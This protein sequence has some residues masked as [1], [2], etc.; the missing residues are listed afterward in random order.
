[1]SSPVPVPIVDL[2]PEISLIGDHAL[3][4]QVVRFWEIAYAQSNWAD[5][6]TIDQIPY[7]TRIS[8]ASL[9]G[10]SRAVA[11]IAHDAAGSA[12]ALHDVCKIVESDPDPEHPGGAV[13]S[14][15]GEKFTHGVLGGRMARDLGM[16]VD[17]QYMIVTHTPQS[18]IVPTTPESVLLRHADLLDAD[19]L[20]GRA[21][22]PLFLGRSL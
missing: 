5:E 9:L 1:M 3:R 2:I 6:F 17:I 13:R 21:G 12:R 18:N 14:A 16:S 15:L 7:N 8:S 4:E 19:L 22:L 20:Y 11:R 10:H